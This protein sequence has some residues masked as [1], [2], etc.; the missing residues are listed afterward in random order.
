MQQLLTLRRTTPKIE[1]SLLPPLR[2][3]V[4][5][6]FSVCMSDRFHETT[7]LHVAIIL[8]HNYMGG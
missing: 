6:A 1:A 2:R 5:A 7:I 8:L 4:T 3:E